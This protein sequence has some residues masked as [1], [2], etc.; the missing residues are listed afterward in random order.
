M[1]SVCRMLQAKQTMLETH[2]SSIASQTHLNVN[3]FSI[4][5][6]ANFVENTIVRREAPQKH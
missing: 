6:D 4:G 5:T 3:E 1:F 2:Q